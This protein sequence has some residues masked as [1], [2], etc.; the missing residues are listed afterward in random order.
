MAS[1]P[2][3]A[4]VLVGVGAIMIAAPPLWEYSN[5][6]EFCGT[7]CH[8]MPPEYHSYLE[9]P[10]SRVPCVDCHIGRDLLIVQFLRKSEHMRLITDTILENYELPIRTH[11]MRPA[12][13]TCE[14]VPF[15]RQV[16]GRQPAR[17]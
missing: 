2:A 9:S 16:F 12:R 15:A 11:S 8:T 13:E 17:H 14:A 6:A 1:S 3:I 10:H 7:T 4:L 5:S